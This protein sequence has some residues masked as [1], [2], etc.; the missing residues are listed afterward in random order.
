MPLNCLICM[1]TA[2]GIGFAEVRVNSLHQLATLMPG[3]VVAYEVRQQ[4]NS[5]A[6]ARVD[7]AELYDVLNGAVSEIA[8]KCERPHRETRSGRVELKSDR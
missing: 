5:T 3:N 2:D 1:S 7:D 4:I 6:G 8:C